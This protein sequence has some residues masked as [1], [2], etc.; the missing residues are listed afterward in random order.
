MTAC[1][2]PI[3]RPSFVPGWRPHVQSQAITHSSMATCRIHL[4]T[5]C[6]QVCK[7]SHPLHCRWIKYRKKIQI[8]YRLNLPKTGT[9]PRTQANRRMQNK[10]RRRL[11]EWALL[12]MNLFAWGR[13]RPMGTLWLSKWWCTHTTAL[14]SS[15][16]TFHFIAMSFLFQQRL[17]I[18]VLP[19][20]SPGACAGFAMRCLRLS[21]AW[22]KHSQHWLPSCA[23]P[24]SM[25]RQPPK[26]TRSSMLQLQPWNRMNRCFGKSKRARPLE[27]PAMV[28]EEAA[29]CQLR[30]RFFP[31]RAACLVPWYLLGSRLQ[32]ETSLAMHKQ[33]AF[34]AAKALRSLRLVVL[35]G[36]ITGTR[37]DRHSVLEVSGIVR[38]RLMTWISLGTWEFEGPSGQR[39]GATASQIWLKPPILLFPVRAR[40]K[41]LGPMRITTAISARMPPR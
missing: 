20:T 33:E 34:K 11:L 19:C 16:L 35:L 14:Y 9:A 28:C 3:L 39:C 27:L 7:Q 15:A 31:K 2:L 6:L 40:T 8:L 41:T 5:I 10:P 21:V 13:K 23:L 12:W 26:G 22:N 38:G 1:N 30:K 4:L 36:I 29:D 18:R 25:W 17:K 37:A 24:R 32:I